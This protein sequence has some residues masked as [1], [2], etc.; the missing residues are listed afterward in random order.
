MAPDG[1]ENILIVIKGGD[2]MPIRKSQIDAST[3]YEKKNYDR[4]NIRLRK[5]GDITE[6]IAR[7]AADAAGES[8]NAY[9]IGAL[10]MRMEKEG[11]L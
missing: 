10:K 3:R 1:K 7:A 11:F 6:E 2:Y 9:T 8:L 5:D 4:L